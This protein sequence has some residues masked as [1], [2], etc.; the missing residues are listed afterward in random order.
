ML[1]WFHG[2]LES[3]TRSVLST[4]HAMKL[5]ISVGSLAQMVCRLK[6]NTFSAPILLVVGCTFQNIRYDAWM[7]LLVFPLYTHWVNLPKSFTSIL[8]NTPVPYN[9]RPQKSG[10]LCYALEN[11]GVLCFSSSSLFFV[12]QEQACRSK[13]GSSLSSLL[14]KVSTSQQ[15]FPVSL[16]QSHPH[17]NISISHWN[18]PRCVVSD[19]WARISLEFWL[20]N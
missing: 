6:R 17:S 13:K 3:C 14:N 12:A 10:I 7:L 1:H 11:S 5:L 16:F 4:E 19:H 15:F 9:P 18:Y 2:C 20:N 8:Y